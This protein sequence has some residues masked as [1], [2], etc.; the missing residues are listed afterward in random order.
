MN[1]DEHVIAA[2]AISLEGKLLLKLVIYKREMWF[3]R[4][5]PGF[6]RSCEDEVWSRRDIGGS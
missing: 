4:D 6:F 5:L 1:L 2:I 3:E